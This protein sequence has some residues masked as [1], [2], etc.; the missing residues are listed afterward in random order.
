[1]VRYTMEGEKIVDDIEAKRHENP[2][3]FSKLYDKEKW[4]LVDVR[5]LREIMQSDNTLS[6]DTY[7][8]IEKYDFVLVSPEIL[9]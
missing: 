2:I 3:V 6:I 1:M 7:K 8:L 9:K 5:S 4:V